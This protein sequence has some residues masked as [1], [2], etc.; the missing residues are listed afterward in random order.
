MTDTQILEYIQSHRIGLS[1]DVTGGWCA[2]HRDELGS[3]YLVGRS[4][5]IRSAVR[6]AKAAGDGGHRPAPPLSP[7]AIKMV[8]LGTY[9]NGKLP[10]AGA[11]QPPRPMPAEPTA[12]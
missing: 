10:P 4:S 5:D 9:A 2:T 6:Q 7:D 1:V 12:P 11:S 3:I 8:L